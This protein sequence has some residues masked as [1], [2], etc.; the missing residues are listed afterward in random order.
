MGDSRSAAFLAPDPTHTALTEIYE[1]PLPG[2]GPRGGDIDSNGVF[3]ASLASGHLASFDGRKCKV[4]NGPTATHNVNGRKGSS[5]CIGPGGLSLAKSP[6]SLPRSRRSP[7]LLS[8]AFSSH[9]ADAVHDIAEGGL[10][11]NQ[12]DRG[13][14]MRAAMRGIPPR[15]VDTGAE[16]PP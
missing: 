10:H 3:W 9:E 14:R 5:A 2:Y 8:G 13:S 1:P 12:E 15:S 7:S 11:A 16:L 4:L 6:G